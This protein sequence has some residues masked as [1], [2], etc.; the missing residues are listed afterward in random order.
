MKADQEHPLLLDRF[1]ENAI[2]VDVDALADGERCF[3]AGVMQHVEE[4]GVH[5]GDSACVIPA[6]EP[7]RGD[8]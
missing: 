4:A 7:R 1:L 6:D 2:E 5:S 3:V 8:A